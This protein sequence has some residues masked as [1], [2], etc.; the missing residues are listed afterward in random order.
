MTSGSGMGLGYRR[1]SRTL[2]ISVLPA[3]GTLVRARLLSGL[4]KNFIMVWRIFY[5]LQ[6]HPGLLWPRSASQI[7]SHQLITIDIPMLN[8]PREISTEGKIEKTRF[9][10]E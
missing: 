7:F 4:L 10:L 8:T 2:S 3:A 9:E 1:R 5:R 6:L